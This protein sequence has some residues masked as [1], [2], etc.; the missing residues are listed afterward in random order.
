MILGTAIPHHTNLPIDY[1]KSILNSGYKVIFS[2]GAN[3]AVNR[4]NIMEQARL[5][6]DDLLIIDSDTV[7]TQEDVE[8]I[9]EH[10]KDKDV[11]T[12]I[13]VLGFEP[14][15]P[16]VFKK[17]NEVYKLYEPKGIEE[18]DACGGGFLGISKKVIQ[19][20][21]DPFTPIQENGRENGNDISF[22]MR[23]KDNG[24]KIFVDSSIKVG[25]IRQEIKYYK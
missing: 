6:D 8:K 9:A 20:I 15:P 5:Q 10:L 11:I 23:V 1:V 13:Q 19:A 12:G 14:Y 21:T 16:S 24:F 4:N 7:F 17:E 22:C 2:E 18:I 25:H 3:V